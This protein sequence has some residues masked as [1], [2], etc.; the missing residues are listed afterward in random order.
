MSDGPAERR[1]PRPAAALGELTLLV[2]VS[3]DPAAVR[4]FTESE[5]DEA[6]QYAREHD[7]VVEPLL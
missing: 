4:A 2:R 1:R 6:E 3:A 5:R 7:S